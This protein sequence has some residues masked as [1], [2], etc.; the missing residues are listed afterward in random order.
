M[1]RKS[2]LLLLIA[3][4]LSGCSSLGSRAPAGVDLT[5]IWDLNPQY[6][7][8]PSELLKHVHH[9]RRRVHRRFGEDREEGGM[10]GGPGG[11][12]QGPGGGFPIGQ[13]TGMGG[14]Y[15]GGMRLGLIAELGAHELDI[16][17]R[18]SSLRIEYD[19]KQ[20]VIYHWGENAGRRNFGEPPSGW[21]K[22]NFVIKATGRGGHGIERTFELSADHQTLTV[23][24]KL[25]NH[26]MTQRYDLNKA[27]TARVYG[28][29]E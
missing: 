8:K 2:R 1:H 5:G 17:Q 18:Q 13:P 14:A 3:A 11:I 9:E 21:I 20:S 19:R 24:T 27:A 26:S 4:L 12:G 15:G 29:Q 7:G 25:G 16:E 10:T 22:G 28:G 23:V 6:S